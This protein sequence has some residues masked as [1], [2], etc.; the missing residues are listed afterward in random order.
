MWKNIVQAG[1]PQMT[2]WRIR[3]ACWNPKTTDRQSE[4]EILMVSTTTMLVGNSLSVISTLPGV[5]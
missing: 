4:Y 2:I 3:I 5:L 1:K